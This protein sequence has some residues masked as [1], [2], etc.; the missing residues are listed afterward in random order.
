MS[1]KAIRVLLIEDN[2]GDAR[3]IRELLAE[4]AIAT[5]SL[6][7]VD[8]L[9]AGLKRLSEGGIDVILLDLGLPDSQGLDTFATIYD[10][11]R[12]VPIVVLTGLDDE[13]LAIQAMRAG[14]QDYLVKGQMDSNL[15]VHAVRYAIERKQLEEALRDSG[16]RFR[17][18]A[19]SIAD[20][21]WEVDEN[22]VYTYCSDKVK[23]ILGYSPGEI[24]GKTPFD[25][26]PKDGA[27]RIAEVFSKMARNKE[28]IKDLENWNV[29]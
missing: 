27:K 1:G 24:I 18:I 11:V 25:L 15:L 20:W 16:E 17:D 21:I 26:M 12:H 22:G 7:C 2:P 13:T 28:S 6:E 23:D 8:R 19:Y 10:Q 14:V 5:F 3:L 4:A 29:T 9:S